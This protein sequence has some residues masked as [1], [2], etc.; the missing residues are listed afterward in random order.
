[1]PKK[2][3]VA[4][5]KGVKKSEV[6]QEYF[7]FKKRFSKNYYRFQIFYKKKYPEL[8]SGRFQSVGR[9]STKRTR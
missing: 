3:V 1:M 8:S 2:K 4:W 9:R 6:I 5:L 7:P